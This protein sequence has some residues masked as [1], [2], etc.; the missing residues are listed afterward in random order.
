MTS[1]V[2]RLINKTNTSTTAARR[3]L[4][5]VHRY[6]YYVSATFLANAED[7]SKSQIRRQIRWQVTSD[8]GD[9]R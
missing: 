9:N 1:F 2:V 3:M 4:C 8:D 6:Y 5:T 7:K